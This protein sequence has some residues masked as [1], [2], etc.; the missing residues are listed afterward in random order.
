IGIEHQE[1][2]GS[3]KDIGSVHLETLERLAELDCGRSCDLPGGIRAVREYGRIRLTGKWEATP[4]AVALPVPGK[5]YYRGIR[6]TTELLPNAPQLKKIIS[7]EKKYTKWFS[8]DTIKSNLL[9]RTRRTGDYLVINAQGGTK[10]LKDY[11]IDQ[12]IPRSMRD[13]VLLVADGSHI[14]WVVGY[15]ISEAAKVTE[16]AGQVI[17]IQISEG[18]DV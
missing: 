18:E 12:K 5:L 4:D 7:E 16:E 11:F 6:V 15:R 17:K 9:L 14:L 10:K 3:M 1:A 8:Y 2:Q 13:Q